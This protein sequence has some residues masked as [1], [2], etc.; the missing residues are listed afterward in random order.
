[1]A[2]RKHYAYHLKLKPEYHLL[3]SEEL[4][5]HLGLKNKQT[6]FTFLNGSLKNPNK[7]QSMAVLFTKISTLTPFEIL[8]TFYP[9]FY[10]TQKNPLYFNLGLAY[11]ELRDF[12]YSLPIDDDKKDH[13][14]FLLATLTES[15]ICLIEGTKMS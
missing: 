7:I 4:S 1:M 8:Q 9:K 15:Q 2:P 14:F 12:I 11:T 10:E 5:S 6:F 3:T 13:G